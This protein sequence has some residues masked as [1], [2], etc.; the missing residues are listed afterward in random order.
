MEHEHVM[1]LDMLIAMCPDVGVKTLEQMLRAYDGDTERLMNDRLDSC[2]PVGNED[3]MAALVDADGAVPDNTPNNDGSDIIIADE[4]SRVADDQHVAEELSVGHMTTLLVQQMLTDCMQRI[5]CSNDI[6]ATMPVILI[7]EYMP[8][9]NPAKFP[10]VT[11]GDCCPHAL[12]LM[13]G[14]LHH[15]ILTQCKR[16]QEHELLASNT[17]RMLLT[18]IEHSWTTTSTLL[19]MPW[20]MVITMTHNTGIPDEE[21]AEYPRWGGTATEQKVQWMAERDGLYFGDAE[22][23]AMCELM[24]HLDVPLVVRI[25]VVANSSTNELVRVATVPN[26]ATSGYVF[27]M[28]HTGEC[29]TS[30]A[31]WQLLQSG[32]VAAGA[33]L[34][35]RRKRKTGQP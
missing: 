9:S 11:N 13:L 27:D 20:H 21:R 6:A 8:P 35:S 12:G 16:K 23:T 1:S 4:S 29:D 7:N 31:H 10:S 18:F 26:T 2:A 3:T 14:F 32:V 5:T 28:L 15:P 24:R 25:W 30:E 34:L 33:S 22:I 19:G 17:R